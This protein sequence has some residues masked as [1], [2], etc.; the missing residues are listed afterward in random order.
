MLRNILGNLLDSNADIDDLDFACVTPKPSNPRHIPEKPCRV[1]QNAE[2]AVLACKILK[3]ENYVEYHNNCAILY[4]K[5]SKNAKT[6]TYQS[7]IATLPK[8]GVL[9]ADMTW[10][11]NDR[12]FA[13]IL[14]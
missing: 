14:N 6:K 2:K 12:T 7:L 1:N 3:L 9:I 8:C 11:A 13:I 5:A 4:V 10:N